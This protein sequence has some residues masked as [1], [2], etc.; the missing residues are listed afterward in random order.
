MNA[1]GGTLTLPASA[2]NTFVSLDLNVSNLEI[3]IPEGVAAKINIDSNLSVVTIDKERFLK[4]GE[5]YISPGYENAENGVELNIVC[6]VSRLVI[7]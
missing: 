6:N 5:Y 3:V 1:S 2:G 4:Q 7:K